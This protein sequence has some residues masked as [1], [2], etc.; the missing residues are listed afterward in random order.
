MQIEDIWDEAID[1]REK[2][3]AAFDE[4]EHYRKIEEQALVKIRKSGVPAAEI[5]A[6]LGVSRQ[7]VSKVVRQ[8]GLRE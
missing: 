1:A 5:A 3:L 6:K 4:A 8:A 2:K 7:W